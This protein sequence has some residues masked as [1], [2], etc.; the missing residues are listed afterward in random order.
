[1]QEWW[2]FK[3]QTVR[4]NTKRNY[5]NILK[6]SS[7]IKLEAKISRVDAQYFQKYFNTLRFSHSQNQ[8][9]RSVLK[10]AFDYAVNMEY[11]KDNPILKTKQPR[12]LVLSCFSLPYCCP[13]CC[14]FYVL[15]LV[16]T[17]ISTIIQTHENRCLVLLPSR[18][19]TLHNVPI[20]LAFR[21]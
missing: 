15:Y 17:D 5:G 21:H 1:M 4:N 13:F 9:Y 19:D 11:L 14:L 6:E 18:S 12:I 8:K 10:I 7:N 3:K 2:S 20:V 16:N